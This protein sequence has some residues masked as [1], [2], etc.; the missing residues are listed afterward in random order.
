MPVP[1]KGESLVQVTS[2]EKSSIAR[3]TVADNQVNDVAYCWSPRD[4]IFGSSSPE[5]K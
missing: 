4:Q 5:R 1:V 3:V 2:G